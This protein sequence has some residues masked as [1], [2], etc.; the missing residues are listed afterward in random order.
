MANLS[1][2]R[3]IHCLNHTPAPLFHVVTGQKPKS[4]WCFAR[5]SHILKPFPGTCPAAASNFESSTEASCSN[6]RSWLIFLPLEKTALW[7]QPLPWP[8]PASPP[9][10][11][12]Y[13]QL[14][15]WKSAVAITLLPRKYNGMFINKK[16]CVCTDKPVKFAGRGATPPVLQLS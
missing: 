11:L 4:R 15:N 6:W 12:L 9:C 7:P 8:M 13:L 1:P 14:A 5:Q 2:M 3:P 10:P 16:R